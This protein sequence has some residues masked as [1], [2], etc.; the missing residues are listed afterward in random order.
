[1]P[2]VE[3]TLPLGALGFYIYDCIALLQ[4]NEL[5]L[6]KSGARW[7]ATGGLD[8]FLFG[9]RICLPAAFCPWALLIR[10]AWVENDSRDT[11]TSR[12]PPDDMAQALRTLQGICTALLIVLVVLLPVV[13]IV[14]GA[15]QWLL[16]VFALYYALVFTAVVIL[17]RRRTSLRLTGLAFWR[18]AFDVLA[19]PPFAANLVHKVTYTS[20][21]NV[22]PLAFAQAHFNAAERAHLIE[23]MIARVEELLAREEDGSADALRL[24]RFR[25][26]LRSGII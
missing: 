22:P 9:K 25:S 21:P 26:E 12:W 23:I 19:C 4:V 16:S 7:R 18:L 10:A 20:G 3:V 2:P 24:S 14:W 5:V 13:S 8:L 11:A 1:M 15:G 6:V 17:Y